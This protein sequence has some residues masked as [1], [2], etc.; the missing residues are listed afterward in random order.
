M[1]SL[2]EKKRKRCPAINP[3]QPRKLRESNPSASERKGDTYVLDRDE[4]VLD[5]GNIVV[6]LPL[7]H[8][9]DSSVVDPRS[10]DRK[11]VSEE[12]RLLL[13]V[14]RQGLYI[15]EQS[16]RCE[17]DNQCV[18]VTNRVPPLGDQVLET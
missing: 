3:S 5:E 14:E 4:V 6:V 2:K 17:S 8:S 12:R 16:I 9:H 11:K 13:E 7:E 15:Q 10:Q 1:S 18:S